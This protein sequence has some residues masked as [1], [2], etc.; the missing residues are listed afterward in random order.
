MFLLLNICKVRAIQGV[1]KVRSSNFVRYNFSSRL[2]FYMKFLKY[3]LTLS[4]TCVQK[5]SYQHPPFFLSHSV[6]VAALSKINH[7]TCR[8][9]DDSFWAFL[10]PS[11]QESLRPPNNIIFRLGSWNNI[12]CSLIQEKMIIP[13]PFHSKAFV[14]LYKRNAVAWRT[15]LAGSK[16][17]FCHISGVS[18][19]CFSWTCSRLNL[20]TVVRATSLV[21]LF[22]TWPSL[23]LF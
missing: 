4:S 11:M 18:K 2:Y 21:L 23:K 17:F 8:A 14:L 15:A 5:F 12:F 16:V 9:L 10:S 19:L 3:I 20:L 6:V 13:S 22:S 1:P 7:V